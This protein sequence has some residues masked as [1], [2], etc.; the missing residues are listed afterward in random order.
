MGGRIAAGPSVAA[1][2][3]S[4]KSSWVRNGGRL[5]NVRK[6]DVRGN[7]VYAA[8]M[9]ADEIRELLRREPFEPFRIKL[10][11]GDAYD[12]RDP[13]SVALGRNRAF[14][15][16]PDTDRWTFFAYLHIAAVESLQAA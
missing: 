7:P 5:A 8:D 1:M 11:S 14:V 12:I 16:F 2:P 15:A 10:T 6:L 13:N 3:N 9:N 4:A